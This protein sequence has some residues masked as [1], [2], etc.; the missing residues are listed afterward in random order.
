MTLHDKVRHDDIFSGP[1]RL[2]QVGIGL[3]SVDTNGRMFE[4]DLKSVKRTGGPIHSVESHWSVQT[5]TDKH[6]QGLCVVDE[7]H[8]YWSMTNW[9]SH[10]I[11][12]VF[13]KSSA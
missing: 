12:Y 5:S 6:C 11:F 7:R 8:I 13:L 2:S 9:A 3:K 4:L 1:P 10:D